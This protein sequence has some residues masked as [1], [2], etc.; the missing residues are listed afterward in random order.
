MVLLHGYSCTSKH[1]LP[2]E[3]WIG[4]RA[5][6]WRLS[7]PGHDRTPVPNDRPLDIAACSDYVAKCLRYRGWNGVRLVGH[8]LGGMVGMQCVA[9]HP[10]LF[11]ALVLVDAFPRLGVP[12]PFARSWWHGSPPSVRKRVVREM[13]ARRRLLPNS[14]WES[15]VAF[16]GRPYL[17]AIRLP[18]R[19]IYGDRGEDDCPRLTKLLLELGLGLASDLELCI[20]PRAGH[21]VMLEQP[22]AFYQVLA[23][24][25][26][27]LP[28]GASG[29][30]SRAM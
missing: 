10:E 7:L 23:R 15:V 1:W 27:A 12:D 30:E 20:I 26:E 18:I 11:S 24:I 9:E 8:S 13:M 17:T 2:A 6:I 4:D 16:D 21:F 5:Q 14:L 28:E 29:V 3:K 25:L 22:Q 19:G